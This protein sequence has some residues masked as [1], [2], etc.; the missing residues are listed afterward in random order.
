MVTPD[1]PG[2][3]KLAPRINKDRA[4]VELKWCQGTKGTISLGANAPEQLRDLVTR[5]GKTINNG[6]TT[7]EVLKDLK[8]RTITPFVGFDIARSGAWQVSSEFTLT[9][10]N[11]GVT[12]GTG[13]PP[14]RQ[15]CAGCETSRAKAAARVGRSVVG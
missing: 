1:D 11:E 9:V 5:L 7:Q 12:A 13:K 8:T 14:R 3:P 15:R 2:A 4:W 10:W 6:G